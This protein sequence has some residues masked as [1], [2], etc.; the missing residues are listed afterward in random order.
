MTANEIKR[1]RRV[2]PQDAARNNRKDLAGC[3]QAVLESQKDALTDRSF[4]GLRLHKAIQLIESGSEDPDPRLVALL[5]AVERTDVLHRLF[6]EQCVIINSSRL[7]DRDAL[8]LWLLLKAHDDGIQSVRKSLGHLARTQEIPVTQIV[9][10]VG[11]RLER[12]LRVDR[13]VSL[14]PWEKLRHTKEKQ[15]VEKDL[16][17][18][19][20]YPTAALVRR[21]LVPRQEVFQSCDPKLSPLWH[22]ADLIRCLSLWGGAPSAVARWAETPDW[23]PRG[24][25]AFEASFPRPLFPYQWDNEAYKGFVPIFE[26][27]TKLPEDQQRRMRIV[28]D[29]LIEANRAVDPVDRVIDLGIS[30]ETLFSDE[31]D[32]H[33]IGFR[34][35]V[36]A[37]RFLGRSQDAREK[38]FRQ[39]K[40]LYDPR[41]S[42]VHTGALSKK[43]RSEMEQVIKRG[44]LLVA[45]AARKVI[46]DGYPDWQQIVLR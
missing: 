14:V 11:L 46:S 40:A 39:A 17:E 9:A 42:A 2:S 10:L 30:L 45:E 21:T 7:L 28:L 29:R 43:N 16:N 27:F 38:I 34:L 31:G 19:K 22:P 44:C 25:L 35:A 18:H 20:V 1:L 26:K 41:S 8:A 13:T 33:E 3:I 37:A 23:I 12:R 24:G 32:R 5:E 4:R 15:L 36:R 6:G